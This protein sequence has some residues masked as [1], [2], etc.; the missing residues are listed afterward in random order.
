MKQEQR[1]TSDVLQKNWIFALSVSP[2]TES[3]WSIPLTVFGMNLPNSTTGLKPPSLVVAPFFGQVNMHSSLYFHIIHPLF[4]SSSSY[5]LSQS[6]HYWRFGHV[7]ARPSCFVYC[8]I[9][10]HPSWPP[11]ITWQWHPLS[12][13]RDN[14][15][16]LQT[17]PNF[18]W[19]VQYCPQ[20][21][22]TALLFEW[23]V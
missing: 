12:S 11:P 6:G 16:C 4:P 8:R 18:F 23:Q 13:I 15:K 5:R 17:L 21:R 9:F 1:T 19:G 3:P 14:Q 10:N 22:T 2:I 20:S 7:G